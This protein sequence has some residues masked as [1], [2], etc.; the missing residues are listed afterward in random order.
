MP[1]LRGAT[2]HSSGSV[3]PSGYQGDRVGCSHLVA[4]ARCLLHATSLHPLSFSTGDCTA[5]PTIHMT[6]SM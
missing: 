5:L 2:H 4:T 3:I 6:S 1:A